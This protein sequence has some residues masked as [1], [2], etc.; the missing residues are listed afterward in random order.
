MA[1]VDTAMGLRVT[2][3]SARKIRFDPGS[4]LTATNVQTAIEQVLSVANPTPTPIAVAASPYT[5]LATD[6]VL[7]VNTSGGP[8]TINM[9]PAALHPFTL[10]IKDDTGNAAAN[11][12]TVVPNGA[13]TIDGLSSYPMDS[14][15]TDTTFVPQSGGYY[16]QG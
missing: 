4:P 9:L 10:E 12:I 13:E 7:L 8:I 11:P 1:V 16:V 15:Y 3:E 6:R 2:V 5:V 14:N